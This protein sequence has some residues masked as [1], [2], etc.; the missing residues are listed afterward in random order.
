MT[1]KS[2]RKSPSPETIWAYQRRRMVS[3]R[4]TWRMV[5]VAGGVGGVAAEA[6]A[7]TGSVA[8]GCAAEAVIAL[9][10]FRLVLDARGCGNAP[11]HLAGYG[12]WGGWR[13]GSS[14]RKAKVWRIE[15]DH[16]C[17]KRP[18]LVDYV[19]VVRKF[20]G[21]KG[22][23]WAEKG[24]FGALFRRQSDR[25]RRSRMRLGMELF[26]TPYSIMQQNSKFIRKLARAYFE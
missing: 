14:A 18:Y 8:S 20:R 6:G 4:R 2:A 24:R 26:S 5:S 17:K 23:F 1:A 9:F 25:D 22:R 13:E 3:M 15:I 11:G 7:E 19:Q 16:N 10:P 12:L 21:L